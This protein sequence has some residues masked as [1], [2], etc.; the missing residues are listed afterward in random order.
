M[1]FLETSEDEPEPKI[2]KYTLRNLV[3]Q[4]LIDN[5]SGIIVGK[6]KNENIM[7]SIK[8]YIN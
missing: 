4:A 7:K 2:L 6:P 3:A 1:L 5:I 8:K